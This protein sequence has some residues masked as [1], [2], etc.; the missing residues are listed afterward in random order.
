MLQILQDPGQ[1]EKDFAELVAD[2]G[3]EDDRTGL[4]EAWEVWKTKEMFIFKKV[5]G[6]INFNGT[7]ITIIGEGSSFRGR[8]GINSSS[9]TLRQVNKLSERDG[10]R[11]RC[12][13]RRHGAIR[14]P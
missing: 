4:E 8:Q 1:I 3:T 12:V 7:P 13:S 6:N 5:I 2:I 11:H 10:K 14:N 9:T